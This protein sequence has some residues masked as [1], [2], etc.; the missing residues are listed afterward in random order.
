M[1]SESVYKVAI[2]V[3]LRCFLGIFCFSRLSILEE[4]GESREAQKHIVAL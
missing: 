4:V 1:I 3:F 2:N